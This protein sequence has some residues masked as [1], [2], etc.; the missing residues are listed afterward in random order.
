M[1]ASIAFARAACRHPRTKPAS[2][3]AAVILAALVGPVG[4]GVTE[5]IGFATSLDSG[6]SLF[7]EQ[8]LL[9]RDGDGAPLERLVVYRCMDDTPFARKLVDYRGAPYAPAFQLVD[10]R[11]GYREGVLRDAGEARV[12]IDRPNA[13]K[14]TA[15]LPSGALVIDAGFD[16]WVRSE[17]PRL[18]AGERVPMAFLVP[19]RLTSYAF[20]VYEVG[21]EGAARRFRLRLG[22]LLGWIAPHIDVVYAEADRRLL[23]FEGLSN[24]RNDAGDGQLKVRIEFRDPPRTVDDGTIAVLA[25]EPL[26][27]C[28]VGA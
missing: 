23:R 21:D 26:R 16:Q 5:E 11:L 24:L 2:V 28:R 14:Q 1:T 19:S 17:W 25:R 3:A 13:A 15:P 18:T 7:R 12:F 27:A 22:G 8:H 6:Q 4:A 10:V 20:N 9:R